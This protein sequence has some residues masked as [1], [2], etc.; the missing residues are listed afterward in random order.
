MDISEGRSTLVDLD[1]RISELQGRLRTLQSTRTQL[2]TEMC[3]EVL[4]GAA[5]CDRD[6]CGATPRKLMFGI[7]DCEKS[8]IGVCVYSQYRDPEHENCLFCHKSE[9][10]D[11]R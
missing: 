8:P 9:D 10:D 2:A 11:D 5:A 3:N 6:C 7:L 4:N 1:V